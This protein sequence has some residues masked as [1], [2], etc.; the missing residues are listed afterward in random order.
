MSSILPRPRQPDDAKAD[1]TSEDLPMSH[2]RVATTRAQRQAVRSLGTVG[3]ACYQTSTSGLSTRSSAWDL[4][5]LSQT[6]GKT[7]L[8]SGFA[9]RC[10]QRF[11]L[12]DVANQP[13]GGH[14]NWHTSGRA[15]SVLSYWR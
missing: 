7:H 13:W 4:D 9:L 2:A 3:C 15:I 12:L 14:P 6:S 5:S 8:G 10:F 1:E 11:S